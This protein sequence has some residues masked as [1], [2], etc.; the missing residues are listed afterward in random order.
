MGTSRMYTDSNGDT[1]WQS[2]EINDHKEWTDGF[3]AKDIKFGYRPANVEQAWHPAPQRQFVII[4]SGQL[5]ITYP[6]GTKRVFGEGEARL[7]ENIT[8]KGHKTMAIGDKDCLTA[9][10]VLEDQNAP[11]GLI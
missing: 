2:I 6:D 4:L 5:Q 11:I 7:M 8:G 9:T 3:N 1:N 10:V